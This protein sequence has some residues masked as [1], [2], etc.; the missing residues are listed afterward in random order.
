MERLNKTSLLLRNKKIIFLVLIISVLFLRFWELDSIPPHLRNDEAALGYNA[1]SILKS[2][3]DEHNQFLPILFESF[4]DWKPGLYIYLT[5]PIIY[6]LGLSELAVRLPSAM[7]GLITIILTFLITNR[8]FSRRV[9]V[10]AALFSSFAP[11]QIIFSRGAWESNV[12]LTFTLAGIYFFL[13]FSNSRYYLILSS[14]FF[15]LTFLT[16][17]G[18][19]ISTPLIVSALLIAFWKNI[20]RVNKE[21]IAFCIVISLL[22]SSPIIASLFNNKLARIDSLS[23][24]NIVPQ[25]YI[26]SVLSQSGEKGS[27]WTTLLYHNEYYVYFRSVIW[28]WFQHYLLSTLF[29]KGDLNPQHSA[30][31]TGAFILLD[32]LF[33]ILGFIKII[34]S[35][36]NPQ[37]NFL[38]LWVILS[39]LPSALTVEPV[40]FV[41]TLPF[42]IP[43]TIIMASGFNTFLEKI[44]FQNFIPLFIFMIFYLISY[45]YFIDQYFV[46]GSKKNIAWQYGYKQVIEKIAPLESKYQKIYIP[47]SGDK[48]YIFFLFYPKINPAKVEFVDIDRMFDFPKSE[49]LY[50]VPDWYVSKIKS[51][52]YEVIDKVD[53]LDKVAIFKIIEFK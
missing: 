17:H 18:A 44:K 11:Y 43:L 24:K 39:P 46:H 7:S 20:R 1:Y 31:N 10:I 8:L 51:P 4:G 16:Y 47:E 45:L 3:R 26:N 53:N 6:I 14:V 27:D 2:A 9:A 19:K 50:I 49:S 32:A 13:R 33:L 21:L 40:N 36:L 22:I 35:K 12:S 25:N 42:F 52:D 29:L 15:A 30:P 23:I 48:P 37:I 28:R 38:I 41:R 34:R 5:T